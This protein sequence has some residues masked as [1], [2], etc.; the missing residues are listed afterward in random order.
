MWLFYTQYRKIELNC[1]FLLKAGPIFTFWLFIFS[2]VSKRAELNQGKYFSILQWDRPHFTWRL[3]IM[4][5][6]IC[7]QVITDKEVAKSTQENVRKIS[8]LYLV[9]MYSD[10]TYLYKIKIW[11]CNCFSQNILKH[12]IPLLFWKGVQILSLCCFCFPFIY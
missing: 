7:L 3:R 6:G 5:T 1:P 8:G 12:L 10:I 9:H 2:H 4:F 11:G